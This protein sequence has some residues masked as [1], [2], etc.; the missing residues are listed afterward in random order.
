MNRTS[1]LI[2]LLAICGA[3][4]AANEACAQVPPDVVPFLGSWKNTNSATRNLTRVDIT[5]STQIFPVASAHA[6]GKCHPT[7][8]DWGKEDAYRG[9]AGSNQLKVTFYAKANDWWH[10]IFADL[11]LTLT[12]VSANRLNYQLQ[13]IYVDY[14]GRPNT[15]VSGHLQ[16]L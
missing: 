11:Y 16:P 9:P 1:Q 5:P 2:C 12:F 14:S 13:T 10:S 7:D 15:V 8:C 3:L 6:F 4:S